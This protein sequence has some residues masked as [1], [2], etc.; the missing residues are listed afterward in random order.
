MGLRRRTRTPKYPTPPHTHARV[1]ARCKNH[2]GTELASRAGARTQAHTRGLARNLQVARKLQ[3]HAHARFLWRRSRARTRSRGYSVHQLVQLKSSN[4]WSGVKFLDG[5]GG[6]IDSVDP[7]DFK[8][9]G[10]LGQLAWCLHYVGAW[11]AT[12]A[13]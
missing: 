7:N 11:V 8:G 5:F 10:V 1:R 4:F 12:T 9:L 13:A 3:S 2:A 6:S